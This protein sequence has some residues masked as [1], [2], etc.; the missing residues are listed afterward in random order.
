MPGESPGHSQRA[1]QFR[2]S[3]RPALLKWDLL[4]RG[5]Q[6]GARRFSGR[7]PALQVVGALILVSQVVG[8]LPDVVDEQWI[9]TLLRVIVTQRGNDLEPRRSGLLPLSMTSRTAGAEQ[10]G[11]GFFEAR[12]KL[13]QAAEAALIAVAH[14]W[15]RTADGDI[16]R[17]TN[18][19]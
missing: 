3:F 1:I 19:G 12:L 5:A 13:P 11:A 6:T 9:L 15:S 8:V 17:Y 10:R 7:P 2:I 16:A 4:H 14:R 18:C